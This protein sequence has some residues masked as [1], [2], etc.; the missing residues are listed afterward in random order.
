[1]LKLNQQSY[2]DGQTIQW[3]K[4]TVKVMMNFRRDA[5]DNTTNKPLLCTFVW[6]NHLTRKSL[7]RSTN[8]GISYHLWDTNVYSICRYC[9]KVTTYEYK[10]LVVNQC[11]RRRHSLNMWYPHLTC[12]KQAW[13]TSVEVLLNEKI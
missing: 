3:S 5:F 11:T 13:K 6:S 1:M 2:I 7:I 4:E 12:L 9:W 10:F 8:Y